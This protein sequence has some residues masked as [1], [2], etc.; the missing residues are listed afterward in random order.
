MATET[1][2]SLGPI[3]LALLPVLIGGVVGLI[4]GAFRSAGVSGGGAA[5]SAVR[6]NAVRS[7][8]TGFGQAANPFGD[9]TLRTSIRGTDIE[10]L[11]E[12]VNVKSNA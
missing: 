6:S 4:S 1:G 11:L 9:L 2:K 8:I 3:G 7:S 5:S 10:L 12:R